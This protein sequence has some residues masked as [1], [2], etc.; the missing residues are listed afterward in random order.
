LKGKKR[1]KTKF[2][3]SKE[4]QW[5]KIHITW[6]NKVNKSMSKKCY[7]EIHLSLDEVENELVLALTP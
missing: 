5:E 4:M 6:K 3:P 1:S 7:I 2:D